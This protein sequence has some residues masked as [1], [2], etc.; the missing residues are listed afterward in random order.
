[1]PDVLQLPQGGLL[2]QAACC[3]CLLGS[4]QG[5]L[6][7]NSDCGGSCSVSSE[8]PKCFGSTLAG[9][10]TVHPLQLEGSP[11]YPEACTQPTVV[12]GWQQAGIVLA[13]VW[14][15]SCSRGTKNSRHAIQL[16]DTCRVLHP[17]AARQVLCMTYCMCR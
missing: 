9:S 8:S 7:L 17:P 2:K 1:M 10:M 14:Q 6:A 5:Y 16:S 15:R 4:G 3:A 13:C 12:S 11:T